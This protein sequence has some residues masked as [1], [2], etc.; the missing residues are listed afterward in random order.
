MAKLQDVKKK[1][2]DLP[3]GTRM[4]IVLG[5]AI[6]VMIVA[7]IIFDDGKPD[8]KKL[9]NPINVE[10]LPQSNGLDPEQVAAEQSR[11]NAKI[12]ELEDRNN[13]KPQT[14]DSTQT[15]E[16][17]RR[18]AELESRQRVASAGPE[19][20][21]TAPQGPKEVQSPQLQEPSPAQEAPK[22][23]V[24]KS[25]NPR[26]LA[27]DEPKTPIAYLPAGSNFEA[28]L[29]NGMDANAGVNAD[30][31]PTPALLRIKTD[32]ILPNL[33]NQDIKECFILVAGY[34]D[35]SSERA[36]MRTDTISCVD[37]S[38]KAFEG[39][40]EG[41]VVGEDGK[42]GVRGRFV[43]R[44]GQ[45]MIKALM[46]GFVSGVGGAFTPMAAPTLNLNQSGSTGTAQ[47]YQYPT[48]DYVLGSGV[49]K[50]L[51]TA[52]QQLSQYYIKM[53]EKLYPVIEIDANRKVT[54]VLI[55]GMEVKK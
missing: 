4:S 25:D 52:G 53:A 44:D 5:S 15:E 7:S 54:V 37:S 26:K 6:L 55:K 2:L 41:Y 1:F 8:V 31:S 18:I 28:V 50:G 46:A 17:I 11:L 14:P 34:G 9:T 47:P 3:N 23:R 12:R 27:T 40:S 36:M 38:G 30:K 20:N 48:G 32:A 10:G 21:L 13:Q 24:I 19:A 45:L 16:L 42:V 35:A 51:Q 29:L 43:S 39:K 49:T 22:L 33:F